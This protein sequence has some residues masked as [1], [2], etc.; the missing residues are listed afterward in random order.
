ME[1]KES[2]TDQLDLFERSY[3]Y[4]IVLLSTIFNHP[5]WTPQVPPFF[6]DSLIFWQRGLH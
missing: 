3:Q 1:K 6:D 2:A 5:S 4:Y